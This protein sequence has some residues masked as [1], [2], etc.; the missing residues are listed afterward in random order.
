MYNALACFAVSCLYGIPEKKAADAISGFSGIKRRFE[1]KGTCGGADVYIDY[2]HHPTE[3]DASVKA[4]REMTGGKVIVIFEPHTY[5]RTAALFDGF[6]RSLSTRHPIYLRY[7]R[8]KG[9]K[10]IRHLISG[11]CR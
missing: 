10:H 4:A 5:S 6:V 3:I 9:D 11:H 7:L 8:G 2:A 1:Y